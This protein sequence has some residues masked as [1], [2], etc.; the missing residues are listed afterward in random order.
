MANTDK[1]EQPEYR[2]RIIS[3][4]IVSGLFM[5]VS[6]L[7]YL[8]VVKGKEFADEQVFQSSRSVRIPAVR[9]KILDANGNSL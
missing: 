3:W 7:W 8:Q 2:L 1:K 6:V 9:G 5:L 4:F